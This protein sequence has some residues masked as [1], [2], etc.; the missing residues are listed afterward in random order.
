MD[1]HRTKDLHRAV[2]RAYVNDIR[3]VT[4]SAE[5]SHDEATG[6]KRRGGAISSLAC[7]YTGH[8]AVHDTVL[9]CDERF[10]LRALESEQTSGAYLV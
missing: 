3:G 9:Q 8:I 10:L 2:N 1:S 5:T 4:L 6:I 7:E